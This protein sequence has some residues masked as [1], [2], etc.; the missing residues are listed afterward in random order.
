MVIMSGVNPNWNLF[1]TDPGFTARESPHGLLGIDF[2][3]HVKPLIVYTDDNDN[4]I[5][6]PGQKQG[7]DFYSKNIMRMQ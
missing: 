4:P 3:L 2:L 7:E 5:D 6:L 1:P